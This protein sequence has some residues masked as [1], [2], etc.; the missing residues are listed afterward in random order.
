MNRLAAWPGGRAQGRVLAVMLLSLLVMTLTTA[1]QAAPADRVSA[2]GTAE[3]K[4]APVRVHVWATDVRVRECPSTNCRLATN[5]RLSRVTVSAF[6]QKLGSYVQ[7][8]QYHNRYW[9]QIV[10]P[11]RWLGWISAVYVSGGANDRPVP[12]PPVETST[13]P[14]YCEYP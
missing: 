4:A 11:Q 14:V 12:G 8:G 13:S 5:E 9:V 3:A 2:A 7:D 10:T 1:A 6:C